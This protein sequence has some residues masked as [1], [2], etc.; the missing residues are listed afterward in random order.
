MAEVTPG[1]IAEAAAA[2]AEAS[3]DGQSAKAVPIPDQIAAAKFAAANQ[4]DG[5]GRRRRAPL[6][7]ARVVPPGAS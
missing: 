7:L 5:S 6:R 1:S 2:P 3:K 4:T